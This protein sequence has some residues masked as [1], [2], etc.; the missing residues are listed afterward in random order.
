LVLALSRVRYAFFFFDLE[1]PAPPNRAPN[2]LAL[3]KTDRGRVP[4]AEPPQERRVGEAVAASGC[5]RPHVRVA[6]PPSNPGGERAASNG[7]KG[8]DTTRKTVYQCSSVQSEIAPFAPQLMRSACIF[9]HLRIFFIACLATATFFKFVC[10]QG[11]K[12]ALKDKEEQREELSEELRSLN[13]KKMKYFQ[14]Q[15]K[16]ETDLHTVRVVDS[17]RTGAHHGRS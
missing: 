7:S 17:E 1:L 6:A 5:D 8:K 13:D 3:Y 9:L 15:S 14:G 16:L 10:W 12:R 4:R 2:H 11:L